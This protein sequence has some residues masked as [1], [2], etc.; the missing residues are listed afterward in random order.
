MA[1]EIKA[2]IITAPDLP[3][4]VKGD[5]RYLMTL[6]R[7]F[8]TE[9]AREVNIANG[10]TAEEIESTEKGKIAA[11]KNFRLTFDRLG[12]HLSWNH[13]YGVDN[14]AYYEVRTN[15]SAG[16]DVGL[17]ERT[18]DNQSDKLPLSY[19]GHIYLLAITKDGKAS[20]WSEI[21]Y[22]KA[23]PTA[24]TDLAL[25]KDQ[26]GTLVSFLAIPSDCIGAN[27]YVNEQR[28]QS[29]DNLFLYTG[30]DVIKK[31][32]VA[33]YDQFGE[34]ESTTIYCVLPDVEN[35]VVERN[36]AQLFFYW[37]AVPIHDVHYVVKVG[38]LPDWNKAVTL[39]ETAINKH[40]Y[41]Y[42]NVGEYYMLIK[43][44]DEHN[45]YSENAAYVALNNVVDISKNVI[46]SLSQLDTGYAGNK[47]NI[48]Y[49]AV[50]R[51][52][53][54][55]D[56]ALYGEYIVDV[57]LPQRYRARNWF[58]YKVIG[59]TVNN[60][61]W[62]DLDWP[63][64][65]EEAGVT[66]WNGVVGDLNGVQI[67]HEI[68]RFTGAEQENLEEVFSLKHETDGAK[69]TMAT[70]ARHVNDYR[71]GRWHDG[72]FIGDLTR[73]SYSVNVPQ[74]FVVSFNL[75]M[76]QVM[77]DSLIVTLKK[78]GGFLALS[79]DAAE[80][81]FVLR[82]SDGQIIEVP[83][84]LKERDWITIAISQ[85]D[86]IRALFIHGF[87]YNKYWHGQVNANPIGVFTELYCSPAL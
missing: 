75:T 61:V 33:Y 27:V 45:N 12:G 63:W 36:G 79:Y 52:I 72:L 8:L 57:Q 19:V 22:T 80:K 41:I 35:F 83:V 55:D 51:E 39:F 25:T 9:T 68:A 31:I 86:S 60:L 40:R 67:T 15:T 84:M 59:E 54:L 42:P 3:T 20:N 43:A 48:Y 81:I 13:I 64:E 14:L 78:S 18:R 1:E 34:G 16:S 65:S 76:K 28:F 71:P 26:Q 17:L 87:S 66:T 56:D 62:D 11:P 21:H 30:T 37:D 47:I 23:R 38:A 73:L 46:I 77:A 44:V 74:E 10:F 82:G 53:K 24:P 58:D 5:G 4:V 69:G 29:P 32:R 6:L 50:N 2:K 49:D 85:T 7:E 70:V